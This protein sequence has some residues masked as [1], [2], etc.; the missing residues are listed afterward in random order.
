A[1]TATGADGSCFAIILEEYPKNAEPGAATERA[2]PLG[3]RGEA[4][5]AVA[6]ASLA[7]LVG[8]LTRLA[9][10]AAERTGRN[11]EAIAREWF[12]TAPPDANRALAVAMVARSAAE[13]T[14][15]VAF[16]TQPLRNNPTQPFP[17]D[18]RPAVRDRVFFTPK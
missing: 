12:R 1:V 11:I 13:L 5:F 6:G 14:E 8:E 4:V 2:Q 7:E 9:A 16:A 18:P 3:A 15:Q 10:F 17:A